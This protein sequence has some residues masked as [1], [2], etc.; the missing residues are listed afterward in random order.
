MTD[1]WEK[2]KGRSE[3]FN[4]KYDGTCQGIDCY[5]RNIIEPGDGCEYFNGELMHMRC[6]RAAER[7]AS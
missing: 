4:A 2:P 7:A 3:F 6:A 1:F 5:K